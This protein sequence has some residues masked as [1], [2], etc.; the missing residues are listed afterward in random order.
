M[1]DEELKQEAKEYI[2]NNNL[3]WELEC[4]R[5][6][7]IGEVEQAY[8]AG[9]KA[10]RPQWHKVADGDLPKDSTLVLSEQGDIVFYKSVCN[11]WLEYSP[12]SDNIKLRKWEEPVAWC[13]IP[14]YKEE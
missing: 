7:P 8:I 2:K 1:T 11:Y 13:E 6:S 5:T 9:R 3:E 10:S 12:N 14:E 4:N